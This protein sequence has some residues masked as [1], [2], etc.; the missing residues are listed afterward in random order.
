MK[1]WDVTYKHIVERRV[2]VAVWAE[3][4]EEAIANAMGG[5]ITYSDEDSCP[6]NTVSIE[7]FEVTEGTDE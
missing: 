7:D 4:E 1:R 5:N 3:T 2:T 6:E